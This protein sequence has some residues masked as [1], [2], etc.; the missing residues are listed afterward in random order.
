MQS[1]FSNALSETIANHVSLHPARRETLCLLVLLIVRF[2][3]IL[4][5][6][7]AEHVETAAKTASV[8]RRFYR[9]FQKVNLDA[10]VAAR[11][12]V[13][14]LGLSGK[15]WVLAIDRTNWNFGKTTINILM[16]SVEWNGVGVPLIFT[17][18]PKAGNSSTSERI[19]LM[20][21]L[22]RFFPDMKIAQITGDRE[23]IGSAWMAY[24][25]QENIPFRLRLRENQYVRR[26]GYATWTLER[27]A[28]GLK[29]GEK[30]ILKGFW[31]L[32]AHTKTAT[33]FWFWR[34]F[35]MCVINIGLIF[36]GMS[37]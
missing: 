20:D 3:T 33:G 11:I 8:R 10:G 32:L 22:S 37:L 23:F 31:R 29:R 35:V 24:L 15:P 28:K 13:A 19:D 5:W 27:H 21:R 1:A 17:L 9:F 6:R 26:D 4:L 16:V 2:G 7:L 25:A 30:R 12:I 18:L 34:F 36:A 14:L